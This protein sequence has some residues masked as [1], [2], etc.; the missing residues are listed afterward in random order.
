[1]VASRVVRRGPEQTG[2][3]RSGHTLKENNHWIIQGF[4]TDDQER[5]PIYIASKKYLF[6]GRRRARSCGQLSQPEHDGSCCDHCEE[7]S[8][9]LFVACGDAPELFEAR[10]AT[11][12]EVAFCVNICV[13]WKFP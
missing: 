10:E 3:S 1:M 9:G 6:F 8:C 13:D 5:A 2:K 4:R 11:F 12:N 7:V